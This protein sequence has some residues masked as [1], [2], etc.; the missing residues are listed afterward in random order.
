MLMNADELMDDDFT[1]L[2][3]TT[4]MTTPMTPMLTPILYFRVGKPFV[5]G[6][7]S[8]L[9]LDDFQVELKMMTIEARVAF[10]SVTDDCLLSPPLHLPT[11]PA[12]YTLRSHVRRP[13]YTLIT[14]S[15]TLLVRPY[16]HDE[17][18]RF[19]VSAMPYY[20]S[21]ASLLVGTFLVLVPFMLQQSGTRP[22]VQKEK[23]KRL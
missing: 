3:I 9:S 21:W 23:A 2:M 17:F 6:R 12:I 13:G 4:P 20:A 19:L 18:D 22:T 11:T 8:S 15:E 5:P 1:T 16:R 14:A 10:E 7:T